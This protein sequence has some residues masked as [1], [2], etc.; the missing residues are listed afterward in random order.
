[1]AWDLCRDAA[2]AHDPDFQSFFTPF[3]SQE[4]VLTAPRLAILS[5]LLIAIVLIGRGASLT[6][7]TFGAGADPLQFV[8]CL[9]WL[10]WAI[11]HRQP[12]LHTGLMWQPLGVPLLWV[13]SVPLLCFVALPFTWAFG[14]VAVYNVLVLLAP[15]LSA[16]AAYG[17]CWFICRRHL[18]AWAGGYVFGFSSYEMAADYATPNLSY[19]FLL[20]CLVLVALRRIGAQA[21]RGPTVAWAVLIMVAQFLISLELCATMAVFGVVAWVLALA[22]FAGRRA[23]LLGL[24]TDFGAAALVAALLL[25]PL[26]AALWRDRA[27]VNLPAIWPYYFV[28]D[29]ANFVVPTRLTLLGGQLAAP[30]T[31]KFPGILQEQGSYLGVPLLAVCLAFAVVRRDAPARYLLVLFGGFIMASLGPG[32]WVAGHFTGVR[33][34]WSLALHLPLIAQALPVRF[35]LYVSLIASL[36]LAVFLASRGRSPWRLGAGCLACLALTPAPHVWSALPVSPFFAPGHVEAALGP[37]PRLLVLPFGPNGPSTYWQAENGFGF[38]ETGGYFGFPPRAMQ[39]YPAVGELFGHYQGKTFGPDL[40]AF[41]AGTGT[42][43]VVAGP[44]TTAAVLAALGQLGWP[45]RQDRDVTIFTVPP[46][47]G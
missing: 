38:S 5:Y 12:L 29:P 27:Y 9:K 23:A 21:G 32:L 43:Y 24:A 31:A 34:P 2:N 39:H 4:L 18:A 37:N 25:S 33:L 28:A 11:A 3:C 35:A 41:C 47:H 17:L 1:L 26:L 15:V 16:G 20:P 36:M 10:P 14:P 40:A 7:G 19:A 13:S 45:H 8:W 44:G 30:L 42:R 6:G 46:A 22:M